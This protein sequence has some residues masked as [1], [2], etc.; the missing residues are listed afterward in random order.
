[1]RLRTLSGDGPAGYYLAS[2]LRLQGT[3]SDIIHLILLPHC[4]KSQM[5]GLVV[6][7]KARKQRRSLQYPYG[8]VVLV[9]LVV[10]VALV[11]P[12][13]PGRPGSPDSLGSP[14]SLVVLVVQVVLIVLVVLVVWVV[15]VV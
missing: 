13:I 8:T 12:S 3:I 9:V 4:L 6:P 15:L 5:T 2:R 10:L 7:G 14:G 11:P 1:M